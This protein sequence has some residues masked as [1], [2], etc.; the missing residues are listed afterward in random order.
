MKA[1][2]GWQPAWQAHHLLLAVCSCVDVTK[3]LAQNVR[4]LSCM[5][6]GKNGPRCE[7]LT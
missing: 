2:D 5:N 3:S 1:A 6:R 4:T 7:V